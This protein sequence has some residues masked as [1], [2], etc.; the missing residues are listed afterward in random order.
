MFDSPSDMRLVEAP[1]WTY[2]CSEVVVKS[3][4]GDSEHTNCASWFDLFQVES[5]PRNGMSKPVAMETQMTGI[6]HIRT[7]KYDPFDFHLISGSRIEMKL[8]VSQSLACNSSFGVF[9]FKGMA[10]NQQQQWR[11]SLRANKDA[12]CDNGCVYTSRIQQTFNESGRIYGSLGGFTSNMTDDY[13]ILL[14]AFST[15]VPEC[16]NPQLVFI[17]FHLYRILY[18]IPDSATTLGF[19]QTKGT[20]NPGLGYFIINFTLNYSGDLTN[21]DKVLE[22][23]KVDYSCTRKNKVGFL[24]VFGIPGI[25]C[26]CGVIFTVVVCVRRPE[27]DPDRDPLMERAEREGHRFERSEPSAPGLHLNA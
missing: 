15:T 27:Q 24:L 13:S 22:D 8:D 11:E 26:V 4:V 9:V 5:D 1:F 12:V 2:L 18:I 17:E 25:A 21:R 10:S 6:S 7:H 16:Q 23:I 14:Y 19:H 3:S 20:F